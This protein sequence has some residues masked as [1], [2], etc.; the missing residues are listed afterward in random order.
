MVVAYQIFVF[1]LYKYDN[2]Q[3]KDA[4]AIVDEVVTAPLIDQVEGAKKTV[5]GYWTTGRGS[6]ILKTFSGK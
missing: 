3:S 2:K 1:E 6:E 4:A 5:S